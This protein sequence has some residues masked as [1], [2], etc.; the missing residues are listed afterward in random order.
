ML[1]QKYFAILYRQRNLLL[2]PLNNKI[3]LTYL[4]RQWLFQQ[5][6]WLG[7]V[8]PSP[9]RLPWLQETTYTNCIRWSNWPAG[10]STSHTLTLGPFPSAKLFACFAASVNGESLLAHRCPCPGLYFV[11]NATSFQCCNAHPTTTPL[12]PSHSAAVRGRCTQCH[13]FGYNNG[14]QLQKQRTVLLW[15][16]IHK[17]NLV[18]GIRT[19]IY[20]TGSES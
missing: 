3:K 16:F 6:T 18:T 5:Q 11:R 7:S 1:P 8:C 17:T 10:P 2:A 20:K 13:L 12:R 19:S 15:Y 9:L 4:R 14:W